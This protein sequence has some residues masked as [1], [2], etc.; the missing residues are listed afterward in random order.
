MFISY[1]KIVTGLWTDSCE[2]LKR[3]VGKIEVPFPA[4][5]YDERNVVRS[6]ELLPLRYQEAYVR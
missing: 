3:I 1:R 6:A 5:C 4:P 2:I